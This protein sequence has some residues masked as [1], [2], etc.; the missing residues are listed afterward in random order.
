MEKI[1]LN[2]NQNAIGW[3]WFIPN[4]KFEEGKP[5]SG[6]GS[7]RYREG[8]VFEGQVKY[9]GKKFYRQGFGTQDFTHS[10]LTA[11][12][13]EGMKFKT[14]YGLYSFQRTEYSKRA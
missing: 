5:C 9:D 3:L 11:F 6:W 7:E 14:F 2:E 1:I 13:E 10:S 4:E 8:S 12:C